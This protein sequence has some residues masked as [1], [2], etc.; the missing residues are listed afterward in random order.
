MRT[1]VAAGDDT[2]VVEWDGGL[3]LRGT[4]LW[5]DARRPVTLS[6]L[7]SAL[8]FRHQQR[9]VT[10][11]ETACLLSER[12]GTSDAL[13]SPLRRTFSV[14]DLVLELLPAGHVVGSAM[15]LVRH[16]G[17]NLLYCGGLRARPGWVGE[18]APVRQ[19]DVL[20]LD[21]PY[22]GAAYRFPGRRATGKTLVE[23]VRSVFDDGARP[24]LAAAELGMAQEVSALFAAEGIPLRAH[25]TVAAWNRRVRACGVP[26]A[27]TPELRHPLR[28][29]EVALV[30]PRAISSASLA[31]LTPNS[32]VALVSG[33]AAISGEV[34]RVGAEIGFVLSCHADGRALRRFVRDTGAKQVYLG[35]RHNAP[36][37][38]SLR[39]LGVKVIHFEG[40]A[41][42][43]QLELF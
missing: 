42:Q 30:P 26:L 41:E 14:G 33:R 35:P 11:P 22:D 5:L 19:A 36:F 20:V 29:G 21:C 23:W 10:S 24:V 1:T 15:L 8:T 7:S 13:A 3:R 2:G 28:D 16:R 9:L 40:P 38:T 4:P 39:R 27:P 25:R 31:K 37:A 6:F 18:P 32:R 34:T 12:L 17:L 43:T